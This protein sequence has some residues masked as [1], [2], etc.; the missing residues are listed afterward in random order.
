[1]VDSISDV[2]F[3]AGDKINIAAT[4]TA[5]SSAL[6]PISLQSGAG[7]AESARLELGDPGMFLNSPL[8]IHMTSLDVAAVTDGPMALNLLQSATLRSYSNMTVAGAT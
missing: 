3:E 6:G 7:D 4:A 5:L 8:S 1:M 2:Q